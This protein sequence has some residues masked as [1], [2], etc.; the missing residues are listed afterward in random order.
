MILRLLCAFRY[1]HSVTIANGV[2]RCGHCGARIET[3]PRETDCL[4]WLQ[5]S[6]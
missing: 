3:L 6:P 1:H 4:D 2:V 5:D